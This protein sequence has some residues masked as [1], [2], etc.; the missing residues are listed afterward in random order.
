MKPARVEPC[1][2][3]LRL[4]R[5]VMP[6]GARASPLHRQIDGAAASNG[7]RPPV[8]Q[9]V[10]DALAELEQ[11]G[12]EQPAREMVAFM[13]GYSHL[14]STGF[15]KAMGGLRTAELIDYPPHGGTVA[16]TDAGRAAATQPERPRTADEN[17]FCATIIVRARAQ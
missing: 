9:R 3:P 7:D 12:A 1:R 5:V 16:L 10:L 11:I 14:Q 2:D 17:A 6:E 15:V 8:Q 13:A 4:W